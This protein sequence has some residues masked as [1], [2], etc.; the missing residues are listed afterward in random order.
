[1]RRMMLVLGP[2]LCLTMFTAAADAAPLHRSQWVKNTVITE[3]YPTPEKW[4]VGAKVAAPGLSGKHR[5]DWLYSARGIVMEG[6][7]VD[8]HGNRVHLEDGGS[9]GWV[10]ANGKRST[11]GKHGFS[12]TPFW[13]AA[14]FWRNSHKAV[15]FPLSAG[16]WSNG[17]GKQRVGNCGIRF[18]PG[19]SLP[20]RAYRSVA[21]DPKRI[22]LGSWVYLPAYRQL[23]YNGWMKAQDTGGAINGY[24]VDVYRNAPDKITDEGRYFTKQRMYVVP[25]GHTRP[26]HLPPGA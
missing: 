1:M 21:V 20:L 7:G 2:I 14:N 17:H 15:T 18:A 26:K 9:C 25:P 12:R 10:A 16:G 4:F 8:D 24:H 3:Y 13:R 19:A 23:G 11:I 5:V 6:D 22:P